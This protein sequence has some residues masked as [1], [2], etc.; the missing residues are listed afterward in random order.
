MKRTIII[1]IALLVIASSLAFADGYNFVGTLNASM[2][3][4]GNTVTATIGPFWAG[5]TNEISLYTF[6]GQQLTLLGYLGTNQANVGA[7]GTYAVNSGDEIVVGI[8]VTDENT[9]YYSGSAGFLGTETGHAKVDFT[10]QNP[11]IGGPVLV[12]FEDMP[13]RVADGDFN[14]A[15]VVSLSGVV[16]EPGTI[17]AALSILA[18]A[19]MLF[20]RRKF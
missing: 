20:R 17:L 8:H 6:N 5:Y 13:L 19:G 1:M 10:G 7:T 14:D 3:A 4:S 18:P 11:N 16:P 9:I 2:Y 15:T 12:G